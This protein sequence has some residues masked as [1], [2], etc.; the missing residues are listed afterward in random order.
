MGRDAA[1][2]VVRKIFPQTRDNTSGSIEFS[3][4]V[5]RMRFIVPDMRSERVGGSTMLGTTQLA[6]FEDKLSEFAADPDLQVCCVV[7]SVPWISDSGADT[8]FGYTSERTQISDHIY[9][10]GIE[11][12]VFMICGDMHGVAYDDGT[13]NHF[14]TDGR[15]G[16]PVFQSASLDRRPNVLK[17]G[18]YS[19]GS[20]LNPG[21]YSIMDVTDDGDIITIDIEAFDDA[22]S[23]LYTYQMQFRDG[24][25]LVG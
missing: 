18:P 10:L 13:N 4:D 14:D 17:G 2:A 7:S 8:W 9:A 19:G 6:A 12:K 24:V 20:W 21:Q 23:S 25:L 1:R 11:D 3:F 22:D 15:M 5:G 16:W